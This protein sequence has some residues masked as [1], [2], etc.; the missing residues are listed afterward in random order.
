M[1]WSPDGYQGGPA[2]RLARSAAAPAPGRQYQFARSI[3]GPVWD[4]APVAPTGPEHP[5]RLA[6]DLVTHSCT[7]WWQAFVAVVDGVRGQ[8]ARVRSPAV[9]GPCQRRGPGMQPRDC[10]RFGVQA[11]ELID[12]HRALCPP[13]ARGLRSTYSACTDAAWRV[14]SGGCDT[15]KC[16]TL[17]APVHG[18]FI[19]CPR[20]VHERGGWSR[21]SSDDDRPGTGS[22]SEQLPLHG[23]PRRHVS[24]VSLGAPS[25]GSDL[26][27]RRDGLV[28]P[29]ARVLVGQAWV[30]GALQKHGDRLERRV[31]EC[32]NEAVEISPGDLTT[33]PL[34]GSRPDRIAFRAASNRA[35]GDR[36]PPR[37]HDEHRTIT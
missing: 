29:R 19:V 25:C 5:S 8:S 22:V 18:V 1:R 30:V 3:V 14:T 16:D 9:A 37:T 12:D 35:S 26:R 31:G 32:I 17:K 33:V 36:R 27:L 20:C 15:F 24:A 10:Q 6:P 34:P 21:R 13:A 23:L 11:P 2:V 7:M 4:R 28:L